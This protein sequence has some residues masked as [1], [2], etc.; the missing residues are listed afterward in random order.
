MSGTRE[1]MPVKLKVVEDSLE[2]EYDPLNKRAKPPLLS[3][4]R[5]SIPGFQVSVNPMGNFRFL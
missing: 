3:S 4:L 1:K 5:A 2:E